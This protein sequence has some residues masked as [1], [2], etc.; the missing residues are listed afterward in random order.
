MRPFVPA[1]PR[2][3]PIAV[4]IAGLLP[5]SALAAGIAAFLGLLIMVGGAA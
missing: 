4:V 1:P 2:K 5:L 3:I